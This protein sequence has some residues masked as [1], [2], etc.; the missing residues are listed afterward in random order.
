MSQPRSDARR[1]T[2]RPRSSVT[3]N[4]VSS[5]R[6]RTRAQTAAYLLGIR[7]E[8][9]DIT[10]TAEQYQAPELDKIEFRVPLHTMDRSQSTTYVGKLHSESDGRQDIFDSIRAI[11]DVPELYEHLGCAFKAARADSSGRRHKKVA[12]EILNTEPTPKDKPAKQRTDIPAITEQSLLPSN[13]FVISK[14]ALG[15][16]QEGQAVPQPLK[17]TYALYLDNDDESSDDEPPQEIEDVVT[18]V[19]SRYPAMNFR[20]YIG[21]MKDRGILY[22]STAAHFNSGFYKEKIG[23]SEGAAYT[24][25]SYVENTYIKAERRKRGRN[26]KGKKVQASS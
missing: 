1:E 13:I 4:S 7:P 20:Q 8:L 21:T 12:I 6:Q 10:D 17:R 18:S 26:G 2:R 14:G 22:L 15:R 5:V 19:H 9:P 11:M 25:H 23:M 24:F 3:I 16:Q